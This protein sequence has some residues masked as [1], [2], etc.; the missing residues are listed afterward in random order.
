[1]SQTKTAE[2][3]EML[4]AAD[5]SL[6]VYDV[7]GGYSANQKELLLLVVDNQSYGPLLSASTILILMLL[8]LHPM[9]S[10]CTVDVLAFSNLVIG[11]HL[12]N[13]TF[14]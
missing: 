12:N 3:Q 9:W 13:K 7:H 14:Y 11:F 10:R 1:M 5:Q 6:T 4:L 2:L 8:L